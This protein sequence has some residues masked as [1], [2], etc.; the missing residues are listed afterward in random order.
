MRTSASATPR[1]DPVASPRRPA[2]RTRPCVLSTP[3][4]CGRIWQG[5]LL[6]RPGDCDLPHLEHVCVRRHLE[7]DRS[8]LFDDENRRAPPSRSARSIRKISRVIRARARATARRAGASRSHRLWR[9]RASAARRPRA[10][11]RAGRG[12]LAIHGKYSRRVRR[13]CRS[14]PCG[15]TRRAAGSPRPTARRRCRASGTC[16]TPSFATDRPRRPSGLPS[17]TIWPLR[18]TARIE[19]SVALPAPLAPSTATTPDRPRAR[20]P[21]HAP[22]RSARRRAAQAAPW[23]VSSVPRYASI[24]AGFARTSAGVPPRLAEVHHVNAVGDP[25]TRFMWCSTSS[26]VSLRSSRICWMKRPSSATSSW[27]SLA[28]SSSSRSSFGAATSARASSI[29]PAS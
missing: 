20:S 6:A 2:G 7:R 28:C 9:A 8:V 3:G 16:A 22:V 19:R 15:R 29:T 14:S 10:C 26:T 18:L 4:S 5:E 13:R 1:I 23:A 12:A 11:R 21:R 25:L 17:K 27:L 24:T